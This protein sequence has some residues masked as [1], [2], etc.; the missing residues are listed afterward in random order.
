MKL[1]CICLNQGSGPTDSPV[2]PKRK[3]ANV[4]G[5][6]EKKGTWP[7]LAEHYGLSPDL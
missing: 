7:L 5:D 4:G 2:M 6:L 1:N 3:E